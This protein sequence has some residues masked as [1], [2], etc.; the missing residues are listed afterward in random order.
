E[1]PGSPEGELALAQAALYI[2]SAPKSNAV[3]R[4]FQEARADVA[5]HG[6][7]EVPLHL[8]NAPTALMKEAGYAAGY[9]YPHDEPDAYAAGVSYFPEHMRETVYY[10]P[11]ERG[12]EVRIA[13]RIARWRALER[14]ARVKDEPEDTR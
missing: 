3:Y 6:S 5:R 9:R 4:A 2:A 12:L 7:A 14:H 11:S 8:R 1:R 10:Q 13:E